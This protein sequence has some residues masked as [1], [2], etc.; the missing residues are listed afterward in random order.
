MST[1]GPHA[2]Y[3]HCHVVLLAV[4]LAGVYASPAKLVL[5]GVDV[6]PAEMGRQSFLP[7]TAG[8]ASFDYNYHYM[9]FSK[10]NCVKSSKHRPQ[11]NTIY[12]ISSLL[13]VHFKSSTFI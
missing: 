7:I 6:L 13:H 2:P 8:K 4:S 5:A 12:F 3:E 9:N 11:I 1:S 10:E